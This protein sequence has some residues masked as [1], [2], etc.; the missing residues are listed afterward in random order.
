MTSLSDICILTPLS[1]LP[2]ILSSLSYQDF[3]MT[4]LCQ[5]LSALIFKEVCHVIGYI[6]AFMPKSLSF[7]ASHAEKRL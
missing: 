7:E 3:S 2:I 4:S 6:K 5:E 1:G